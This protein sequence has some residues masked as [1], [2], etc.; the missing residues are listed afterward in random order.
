M[1]SILLNMFLAGCEEGGKRLAPKKHS[2]SHSSINARDL[3]PGT[4][5][6]WKN[7]IFRSP[8]TEIVPRGPQRQ[9][10]PHKS[11]GSVSGHLVVRVMNK[12]MAKAPLRVTMVHHN[13][14]CPSPRNNNN[15]DD[16]SGSSSSSQQLQLLHLHLH[17]QKQQLLNN[18]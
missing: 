9:P 10:S 5:S 6:H 1:D 3:R 7:K 15:N 2:G 11:L 8:L 14:L 16:G 18:L 13:S 4:K 12:T 17:L